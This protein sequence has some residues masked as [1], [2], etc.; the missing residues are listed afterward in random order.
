MNEY[1][2]SFTRPVY[3]YTL[4]RIEACNEVPVKIKLHKAYGGVKHETLLKVI[5]HE[6]NNN[7]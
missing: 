7:I 2:F 5:N 4:F 3:G 6:P 1:I